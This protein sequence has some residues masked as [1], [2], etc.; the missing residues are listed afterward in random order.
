VEGFD[1]HVTPAGR[2]IVTDVDGRAMPITVEEYKERLAKRLVAE[3]NCLEDFRA[4]WIHPAMR[5]ALLNQLPDGGRSAMLM[6]ELEDMSDYDLYDVLAE[7]GYGIAPRTRAERSD[8]FNYKSDEWLKRMP[9][10]TSATIRAIAAQFKTGGTDGLE[11]TYIFRIPEVERAG[12]LG[13]L[14]DY[15]TPSEILAQTKE[16]MFAA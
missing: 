16:R 9:Q 4:R 13:A 2:Y 6:R 12:G 7:I 8:A 3:A 5:N 14:R 1:V 15:G 11:S 10:D